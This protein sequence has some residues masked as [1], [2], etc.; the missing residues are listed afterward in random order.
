MSE[1]ESLGFALGI[2]PQHDLDGAIVKYR[3]LTENAGLQE[4]AI[5]KL[6]R[7]WLREF[8]DNYY[9]GFKAR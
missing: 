1:E 7:A 5:I 3:V 6:I 4:E 8:E 9:E 2:R